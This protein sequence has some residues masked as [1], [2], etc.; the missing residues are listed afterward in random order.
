VPRS[1]RANWAVEMADIGKLLDIG[2]GDDAAI[3]HEEDALVS[4]AG[5]FDFHDHA[6]GGGGF[7]RATLTIWKRGRRRCREFWLV[8]ETK[9]SA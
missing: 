9:P 8:P 7:F 1:N 3:G 4:E 5:V 6:A 2:F